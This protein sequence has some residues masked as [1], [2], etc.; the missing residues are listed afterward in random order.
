MSSDWKAAKRPQ[1]TSAARKSIFPRAESSRR[2]LR[3]RRA[4][5]L[6]VAGADVESICTQ[7][8]LARLPRGARGARGR[9]TGPDPAPAVRV[10]PRRLGLRVLGRPGPGRRRRRHDVRAVQSRLQETASRAQACRVGLGYCDGAHQCGNQP[11]RQAGLEVLF[12]ILAASTSAWR[13]RTRRL[14]L[15][16]P[17]V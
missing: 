4:A 3:H 6:P 8:R 10:S 7:A 2:P 16:H 13:P 12:T 9:E 1:C 15:T 17:S 14:R 5:I 11:V